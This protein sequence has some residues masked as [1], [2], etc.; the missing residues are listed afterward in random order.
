MLHC[1]FIKGLSPIGS[2]FLNDTPLMF[3]VHIQRYKLLLG[4][5]YTF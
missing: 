5:Y 3:L 4:L 1:T 2:N